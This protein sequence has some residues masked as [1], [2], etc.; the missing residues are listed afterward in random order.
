MFDG[1][2][3]RPLKRKK[4]AHHGYS[5]PSMDHDR[6]PYPAERFHHEPETVPSYEPVRPSLPRHPLE[7]PHQMNPKQMERELKAKSAVDAIVL[8]FVLLLLFIIVMAFLEGTGLVDLSSCPG[9]SIEKN[10]LCVSPKGPR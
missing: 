7:P 8:F 3:D 6:D 4:L 1:P 10:G 5:D 2:E 9:P